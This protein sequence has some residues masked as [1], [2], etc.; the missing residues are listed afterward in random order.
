VSPH[1]T[2]DESP[3]LRTLVPENLTAGASTDD[4]QRRRRRR[5]FRRICRSCKETRTGSRYP[6]SFHAKRVTIAT[7]SDEGNR[8]EPR[9]DRRTA[10]NQQVVIRYSS[11]DVQY[12]GLGIS[13]TFAAFGLLLLAVIEFVR[14]EMTANEA[15]Y[16]SVG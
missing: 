8:D 11:K 1:D 14:A 10:D 13:G 7:D 15:A 9:L 2:P 4:D 6:F 16:K 5:P 12:G 3:D